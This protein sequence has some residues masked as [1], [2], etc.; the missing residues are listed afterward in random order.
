MR[1]PGGVRA[2][3][4][5]LLLGGLHEGPAVMIAGRAAELIRE[6]A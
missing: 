3:R 2:A 1:T 4:T 6:D 5:A